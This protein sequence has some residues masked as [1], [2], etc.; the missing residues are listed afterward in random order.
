LSDFFQPGVAPAVTH[1]LTTTFSGRMAK[2]TEDILGKEFLVQVDP[3]AKFEDAMKDFAAELGSKQY[4]IFAFAASGSPVYNALLGLGN[5]RFFTMTRK[6]SYPKPGERPDEVLVPAA[7]QSVLLNVLDKAVST[8][9]DLKV[10]VVFDSVTDLILTSGLEMTY[11]FLKQANEMLSGEKVTS[12][13]LLTAGAHSEKEINV[14]KS[15]FSNILSLSNGQ[16]TI[17]KGQ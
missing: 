9:P 7:D 5:V 4:V 10:G 3:S 8:S 12:V 15:L 11:K 17:Q 1:P 2:N 14:V 16:L 13:F 6:V